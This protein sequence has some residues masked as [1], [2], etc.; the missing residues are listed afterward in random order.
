MKLVPFKVAYDYLTE[1][2]P[3]KARTRTTQGETVEGETPHL[4]TGVYQVNE[5]G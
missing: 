5:N 2:P 1:H 3:E 4:V